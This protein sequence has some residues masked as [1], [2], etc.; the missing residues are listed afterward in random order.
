VQRL[1]AHDPVIRLDGGEHGEHQARVSTRRLRS[2]LRTFE[3]LLDEAWA[4]SL[5]ADLKLL[6][7]ALGGVR[8]LDVLEVRLLGAAAKL[9]RADEAEAV[10]LVRRVRR[11]REHRR[12]R[13][14]EVLTSGAYFDLL[15]RLV[16]SARAPRL[17]TTAKG[18]AKKV[19]P[20]LVATPWKKLSKAAGK[21][22]QD[23]SDEQLHDLRIKAKRARYAAEA[24][25]RV[26]AAADEHADAIAQVQSVLG[27]QHD[28]VVA[29]QWLR[30][31][32]RAGVSRQQALVAGLLIAAER[33]DAGR[34]R[35]AWRDAWAKANKKKVRAWIEG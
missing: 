22:G 32:V 24:V 29:E 16:A 35:H 10:R 31:A 33:V 27:D 5:R 18:S 7:D 11:E 13:L 34:Q 23:A 8:D 14:L 20:G 9:D 25:A 15:D 28:A 30:Q 21:L 12:K 19:L 26:V 6:A 2:D 4:E 1:L 3:P 17:N